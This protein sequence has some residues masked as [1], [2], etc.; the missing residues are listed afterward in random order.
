MK[1]LR[2][3]WIRRYEAEAEGYSR[4]V[5]KDPFVRWEHNISPDGTAESR[6]EWTLEIAGGQGPH[7][8]AVQSLQVGRDILSRA[9]AENRFERGPLFR[10]HHANGL[11]VNAHV[12]GLLDGGERSADLRKSAC[13]FG[14]FC[15]DYPA[16]WDSQPQG[17]YL[18]GV[19]AALVGGDPAL[20][21]QL[22]RTKK[23]FKWHA[24]EHAIWRDVVDRLILGPELGDDLLQ[25]FDALF[26]TMRDPGH[27]PDVVV[28]AIRVAWEMALIRVRYWGGTHTL[29]WWRAVEVLSA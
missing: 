10:L 14:D 25:R 6:L 12:C 22:L 24:E 23:S 13:A 11:A 20:A 4:L 5:R 2:A 26:D 21:A 9:F 19:R 29:D 15:K 28:N 16:K 7:S 17:Y 3:A 1:A 27:K 8:E 18:S